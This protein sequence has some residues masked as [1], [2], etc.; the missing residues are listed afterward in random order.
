MKGDEKG[1]K[2]ITAIVLTQNE[3]QNIRECIKSVEGFVK[4]VVVVDSGSTDK[5]LEIAKE[6]GADVYY[7]KFDYYARQFNWG[8]DNTNIDTEWILRLDADERFTPELNAELSKIIDEHQG[9]DVNGITISADLYFMG[10]FLK[11]GAKTRKRK[12]MLFKTGIGRIEDRKRDA[13]SII[14]EG[15]SVAAKNK[16]IHYDFKDLDTYVR[17]L[18]W[19]AIREMQDYFD[20]LNSSDIISDKV[21]K[22]VRKKKF[23]IY[24]KM[25][26]FLRCW[27]LF[28]YAY[29]IRGN[30]LNGVE[31]Y[32]FTYL[33]VFYYRTLVDAKIREQK[34][35]NKPLQ[36]MEAF[37]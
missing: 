34:Q 32:V 22:K 21:L 37:K 36:E 3:E 16:F 33:S 17:K 31:G 23:G 5:T 14:S 30:F 19:Y 24:Y 7:N 27:L 13:H 35:T 10:K 4:R 20:N 26:S 11:H 9:D 6:L 18:D 25:P 15:T 12:M 29:I 8:I 28:I 2:D 1:M